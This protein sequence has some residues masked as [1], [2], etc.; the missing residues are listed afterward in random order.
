MCSNLQHYVC[1]SEHFLNPRSAPLFNLAQYRLITFNTRS[2]KKRGGTLVLGHMDRKS[3]ELK[4]CKKLY[5]D[6]FFEVCG[7]KDHNTNVN[8]V[9]CYR[10]PIDANL[11]KFM[12][13]LELLLDHFFNKDCI[14]C[15]D[16]NINLLKDDQRTVNFLSLLKSYNFRHLITT[17]TF[18]R[19]ET[20]SCLDN[21]L[22]NLPEDSISL[23]LVDHN[24]I[25]DGHAGLLSTFNVNEVNKPDERV[26]IWK[27]TRKINTI[28]NKHFRQ[29]LMNT[30]LTNIGINSFINKFNMTF[31]ESFK[32]RKKKVSI[33]SNSKINWI[34][35]GVK[36]SS[37]MKRTLVTN[38]APIS[39]SI[40]KYRQEYIS[41]FRRVTRAAKRLAVQT[42][43]EKS[44]NRPKEIW[45][46]VNRHRNKTVNS[47]S[48]NLKLKTV[49]QNNCT[50]IISKPTD[51]CNIFL[52]QFDYGKDATVNNVDQALELL[53]RHVPS[54]ENDFI[55]EPVTPLEVGSLVKK[56]KSKTS[57]GYD[58][59]PITI[60]KENIDL[61]QFPL[62]QFFNECFEEGCFPDQ[63]KIAK[64]IP[65]HKKGSKTDSKNY[66]PI[67]LLPTLS[68]LLE[69]II[70]DRLVRHLYL[71]K[72]LSERQFG[73]QKSIGTGDAIRTLVRD[74]VQQLNEK[75]KT[76]GLFMD[77]SSAFD[78]I[79]HGILLAKL[80][81]YGVRGKILCLFKSYLTNRKQFVEIKCTHDD[82]EEGFKSR[83]ASVFR[84]V[85]QGSILGPILFI[86]FTNDMINHI[87][88]IIPDTQ[89]TVFADDTNAVISSD[90]IVELNDRVNKALVSFGAWFR[91]NNLKLNCTKTKVLLFRTTARNEDA[92]DVVIEGVKIDQVES[93]KFLGIEIDSMLNWKHE[94]SSLVSSLSS[95]CYA[96]RSLRNVLKINQLKAV[97]HALVE[98]K[99]R[100]SIRLWGNSYSYN[101]QSAFIAQKRA[102]RIMAKIP[103]W[104]SCRDHFKNFA[105]LTVPSL[106]VLV[107]LKELV[108]HIH[109]METPEERDTRIASR[110]KDLP[111]TTVA[112]L[113]VVRHSE[114]YQ[115]I[116]LYNKLP[117]ELKLLTNAN[118]FANK[119]KIILL[120]QCLYSVE[121]FM[122]KV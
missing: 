38:I 29:K 116:G 42:H 94:L 71:N 82:T 20:K 10:N 17:A 103:Q 122:K 121:D 49:T 57:C 27:Q 101:V 114:D 46:I 84:G 65:I 39:D 75:R 4:I 51:I 6:E 34:T 120:E 21:V 35:K 118:L 87:Y 110:R 107:V 45:K 40:K 36:V 1:V 106:Y 24:G 117:C 33:I 37:S 100:Y 89:V 92:L 12:E 69:R 14:I 44:K 105:I 28:T 62:A 15:G 16:F 25:A 73:Y 83:T 5:K 70:K 55:C 108:K 67:S 63:L 104:V 41:I 91:I 109:K 86:I 52:D 8:L 43:I 3:E 9:C 96:L 50:E 79:N 23:P 30:N 77:L 2:K 26:Q 81:H 78:T 95:S 64:V 112:R 111:Q 98:S 113:R 119:L 99:L 88:D 93:A 74:V 13:S 102:I 56:L 68:K 72:I 31:E 90:N 11:S 76:A 60:I 80:Q 19:N 47:I 85:P 7:I 22:T 59:I 58:E 48:D 54:V 97:Y 32:K 18:I 61:L 66:R 115:G 53:Q